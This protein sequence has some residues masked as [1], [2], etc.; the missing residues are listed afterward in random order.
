MIFLIAK[1]GAYSFDCESLKLIKSYLTNCLQRTKVNT[2][3]SS[4]TKLILGIPH[5]PVLGPL[6]FNIYIND[7]FYLTEMIDMCNTIDLLIC[8]DTI[9]KCKTCK[10]LGKQTTKSLKV[11]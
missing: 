4:W 10:N 3:F 1:L 8:A 11:F 2:S 6:L 7:L 5:G 9:C